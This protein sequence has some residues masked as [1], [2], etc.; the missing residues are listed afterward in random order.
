MSTMSR[1]TDAG[2]ISQLIRSHRGE[3]FDLHLQHMNPQ[4]IRV[5][6]TIGYDCTY[7]N[8]Q[9]P[10]LWDDQGDRYL[11]LIS[12]WGAVALGRNHPT[13]NAALREVLDLALPN[14][15]QMDASLLSGL[16]AKE[17]LR[18]GQILR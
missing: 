7:V 9:G 16:L 10:Y 17:F 2:Y 5:L 3:Q 13:V 14:M 12:G 6:K 18:F 15:G 8:A 1:D 4:T 11:D